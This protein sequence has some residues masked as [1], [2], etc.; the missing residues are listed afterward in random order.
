MLGENHSLTNE[1]PEFLDVITNL[2]TEDDQF[3]SEAKRY[4]NLDR[5][6]RELEL[7]GSP[8]D[9]ETMHQL[10]HDRAELKDTLHEKL[11]SAAT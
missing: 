11:R 8:V 10:K 6:I 3:A 9:D 7:N 4:D 2:Y 5:E 1:F